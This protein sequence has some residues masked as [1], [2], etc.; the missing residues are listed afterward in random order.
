MSKSIKISFIYDKEHFLDFTKKVY[1]YEMKHSSKR[2]IG[3]FFIALT[4]FG[5]VSA[6]KHNAYGLLYIS[7]FLLLYWYMLRW[8][9]R[10]LL[11]IRIFEKLPNKNQKLSI[12]INKKEFTINDT[13]IPFSEIARY[14]KLP[15]GVILYY[16]NTAVFFPKSVFNTIEDYDLF[17]SYL[18]SYDKYETHS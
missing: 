18:K 16:H 14:L 3:W 4:Q 12:T 5:I 13:N 7:T 10:K 11:A 1:D 15:D 17:L 6:L 9:L 8:Q 2:Y